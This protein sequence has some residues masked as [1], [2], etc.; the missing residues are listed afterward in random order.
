VAVFDPPLAADRFFGAIGILDFLR[1][2]IVVAEA[3]VDGDH[4][5]G[6]DFV[7]EIEELVDTDVV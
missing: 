7:T 3:G 1:C 6:A 5:L 2:G 4:R